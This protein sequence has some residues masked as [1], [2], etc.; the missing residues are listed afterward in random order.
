MG[1]G[2]L[3]GLMITFPVAPEASQCSHA[4]MAVN[5]GCCCWKRW[6]ERQGDCPYN[7]LL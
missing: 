6:L 5:Y 1:I 4:I 2:A 3:C 7:D